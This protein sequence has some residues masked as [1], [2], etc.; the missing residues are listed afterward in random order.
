MRTLTRSV[1]GAATI[2][3]V[4]VAAHAV[5]DLHTGDGASWGSLLRMATITCWMVVVVTW[6]TL[7]SRQNHR[8]LLRKIRAIS[9]RID[10]IDERVQELS[11]DRTKAAAAVTSLFANRDRRR[12][13]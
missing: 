3:A 12:H 9:V 2:T 10:R 6:Q 7:R 1:A 13:M 11:D 8:Q 4:T 5:F